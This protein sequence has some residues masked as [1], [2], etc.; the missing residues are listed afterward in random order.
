MTT[1]LPDFTNATFEPGTPI[2]NQYFPLTIGKV[3]SYQGAEYETEEIIEAVAEEIGNEIAE[4]IIEELGGKELEETEEGDLVELANEIEDELEDAIDEIVDDIIEELE[5]EDIEKF[6]G[7]ELAE[8]IKTELI[9]DVTEELTGEEIESENEYSDIVED[10]IDEIDDD[11]DELAVEIAEEITEVQADLF[12]TETNQIYVTGETKTILGVEATVVRDIAWDE[13][14][15]VED[16][17][18]W[19]AQDT[20]GNIWYLGEI[21]NNYEYDDEG[22]FIGTNNDSSW[23]AGVDGALPGYLMPANPQIGDIYYQEFDL[24]E[25]EDEAEVISLDASISIDFGNFNNVLQTREFTQLEPEAFEYKYFVPGIGQILAEEGIIEEGGEAEL[26]PELI[27]IREISNATIPALSMTNF[28]HSTQI[29]NIYFPLNP[30]NLFIYKGLDTDSGER[31]RHEVLV[32]NETEEI[33][34]ITSRVVEDKEFDNDLLVEE[35]LSYYAQD[36]VGNVW[37]LGESIAEYEYDNTGNIIN[38]DDSESWLAG[39]DQ[40][41]PGLIMKA[42]PEN[43]AAYYQRFDIAEAENQAEIVDSDTSINLEFGNFADVIQIR[44]S[45]TQEPEEFDYKYYAPGVGQILIEEVEEDGSTELTL[46]LIEIITSNEK[47]NI[48]IGGLGDDFLEGGEGNNR[49][50]GGGGNDTLIGV[51]VTSPESSLGRGERDIL[52][53]NRGFDSV[54]SDTFILGNEDIVFYDDRDINSKGADD[55]AR[56]LGFDPEDDTIQLHGSVDLYTL[57]FGFAQG[58]T[59]ARIL[60]NPE[61]EGVREVIA[62]IIDVSPDLSLDDPAFTFV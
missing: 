33:L 52:V 30:G 29:N 43:G 27:D 2:D 22:N 48:L 14:V 41:L 49:I 35:K 9:E 16:T 31:E 34:G 12:A 47:N 61:S 57:K 55:L 58:T 32:T 20:E 8:A 50:T 6:D 21:A 24:G 19:Y 36:T 7:V 42:T 53:G 39:Q 4:E 11:I 40:S 46:E 44:E 25:A 23:E 3:L 56:I 28:E 54:G 17:F 13:G 15:L 38:I 45:S 5:E 60:Y 37:L 51:D 18:D 59:N 10:V 62:R 1:I 26:A